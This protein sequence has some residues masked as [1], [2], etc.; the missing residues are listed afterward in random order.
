[1]LHGINNESVKD[2]QESVASSNPKPEADKGLT[3]ES[4]D[5]IFG[6]RKLRLMSFVKGAEYTS[7]IANLMEDAY[8]KSKV[9]PN[10]RPSIITLDNTESGL[11]Y[12]VI[13]AALKS[14][15]MV[16]YYSIIL[17][18]TGERIFTAGDMMAEINATLNSPMQQQRPQIYTPDDANDEYLDNVIKSALHKMYNATQFKSVDG[19]VLHEDTGD[20]E[21][22]AHKL[23]FIALLAINSEYALDTKI[24]QDINIATAVKASEGILKFDAVYSNGTSKNDFDRPVRADWKIN[25][26]I[27]NN[28]TSQ[29]QSINLRN[30][31]LPVTSVA[32]YVDSIPEEHQFPSP[33]GF[34][35]YTKTMLRPHIVITSIAPEETSPCNTLLS[36]LCAVVMTNQNMWVPALPHKDPKHQVGSLNVYTD[37]FNDIVNNKKSVP[38]MINLTDKSYRLEE[39]YNII[40]EMYTLEPAISIDIP[41]FGPET[42]YLSR[43]AVAANPNKSQAYVKAAA[44]D[45]IS[46]ARW[47]TNGNFPQDYPITDIFN[48]DGIVVPLGEWSDKTGLRDIRDIDLA[49]IAGH[50]NDANLLRDYVISNLPAFRTGKDPFITKV[51]II[52]KFIPDA[53]ID[54]KAVRITFNGKFIK[55]LSAAAIAAGL[56]IGYSPTISMAENNDIRIM[57]SALSGAGVGQGTAGFAREFTQQGATYNTRFVNTGIGRY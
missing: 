22:T 9:D 5:I 43:L 1:M 47:L 29:I 32:G 6:S 37:L 55:E 49:F 20:P 40:R 19:M 24:N 11:A 12:S 45:I 48:S 18:A 54:G 26:A 52:S 53:K 42:F 16:Y 15:N 4:G 2:T 50:S 44:D 23:A 17:E 38:D 8:V 10:I 21:T 33:T 57:A 36:V 51:N 34:G 7:K 31:K 28:K 25:L 46:T 30:T 13:V 27:H 3:N 56:N 35:T 39:V 41:A 14:K